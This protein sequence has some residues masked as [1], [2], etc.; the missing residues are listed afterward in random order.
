M[1]SAWSGTEMKRLLASIVGI[2]LIGAFGYWQLFSA[3]QLSESQPILFQIEAGQGLKEI[4]KNLEAHGIIRSDKTFILY[5]KLRGLETSLRQGRY[6]ISA[7]GNTKTILEILTNPERGVVKVTIPEGF[8]V[9]NIDERLTQIGIM[10]PGEFSARALALEGLLFPDTY[11]I[12]SRNFDPEDLIKKMQDNFLKKLTS[13]L[14]Q[15]IEKRKRTLPQIII[16][17]SILEKEVR[18]EKDY[19]LVAGILWKRLDHDW[20]LQAD[21]TLLYGKST[22]IITQKELNEDSPYNTRK[23][24]GLPPT[25]INNPGIKTI[26]ASI[27]SEES[28][29][30]FYLTDSEGNVHYAKTNEEQNE[31]RRRYL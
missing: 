12:F 5:T 28:P 6:Q 7:S 13:D 26:R 25:P 18:T 30:W 9:R 22:S 8:S 2:G 1:G 17:A 21:A 24:K 10:L 29:Y 19:P 31:N 3:I 16:M 27:F 20:A 11:S 4:S 23:F 14:L 15:E